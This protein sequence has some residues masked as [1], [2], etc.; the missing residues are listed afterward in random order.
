MGGDQCGLCT[1]MI[2]SAGIDP[3]PGAVLCSGR[4]SDLVF[5]VILRLLA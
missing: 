5:R 1:T 3:V 4:I 2:Q